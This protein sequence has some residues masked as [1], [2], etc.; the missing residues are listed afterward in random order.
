[1]EDR[2]GTN[3][4]ELTNAAQL[5]VKNQTLHVC[6]LLFFLAINYLPI[7][8]GNNATGCGDVGLQLWAR[9]A[10]QKRKSNPG[11]HVG[12]DRR[13]GG[14]TILINCIYI[15]TIF[16]RYPSMPPLT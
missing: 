12:Q 14:C 10:E 9:Q 1:M 13:P 16:N 4:G 2:E 8:D 11:N 6:T 7:N 15:A 3:L 5:F